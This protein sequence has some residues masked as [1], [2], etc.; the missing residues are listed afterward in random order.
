M[1]EP[2]IGQGGYYSRALQGGGNRQVDIHR[3]PGDCG[4]DAD[5]QSVDQHCPNSGCVESPNC[6]EQSVELV[7]GL[8]VGRRDP[9]CQGVPGRGQRRTGLQDIA[10]SN[11]H[12]LS[13][14]GASLPDV[15]RSF[16]QGKVQPG[17]LPGRHL[18]LQPMLGACGSG[19]ASPASTRSI[20]P[21]RACPVTGRSVRGREPSNSPR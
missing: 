12:I 7:S 9:L 20:A 5:R 13:I 19:T 6:V 17:S 15:R 4:P 21:R 2:R 10:R 8:Q 11:V 16:R 18:M 1:V 14:R 3:R